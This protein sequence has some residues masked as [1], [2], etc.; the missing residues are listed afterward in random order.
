MGQIT[1]VGWTSDDKVPKFAR[2]TTYGAGASS[3]GASPKYLLVCGTKTAA[4]SA[5][6]DVDIV[7]IVGEDQ[8][9]AFFGA[10]SEAAMMCYAALEVPGV[11]LKAV[12]P[13]EA[14]GATAATMAIQVTGSWSTPGTIP[15]RLA[16]RTYSIAVG[17]TDTKA[18]VAA[19]ITAAFN[20]VVRSPVSA[21]DDSIDTTTLTTK[22][23]GARA[24]DWVLDFDLSLAP[25]GLGIT[26]TGGSALNGNAKP[27]ANG[28]GAD[29]V[30]NVLALM[31]ERYHYQ[32]WA[33]YDGTNI[34]EILAKLDSDAG[35]LVQNLGHAMFGS[36]RAAAT[37]NSLSNT[38]LNHERAS[39][40]WQQNSQ[41]PAS[42]IAANVMAWRSVMESS[43][44]NFN[45]D[46]FPVDVPVQSNAADKPLH[47][48]LK[49]A[50]NNGVTPLM[51]KDGKTVIVRGIVSHCKTGANFDYST[52]DWGDAVV[53]DYVSDQLAVQ[54][55]IFRESNPY[56]GPDP[57]DDEQPAPEGVGTPKLWNAEAVAIMKGNESALLVQDVDTNPPES[58]WDSTAKRILTACPVV[59]RSQNHQGGV[60]VRQTAAA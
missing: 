19:A 44:P 53:P 52:L 41:W 40:V 13:A 56:A 4:G 59:V 43:N 57:A 1:I 50:L 8:A 46:D 30:T 6:P 32:A 15:F 7:D 38:T 28:T 37:A 21:A 22:S 16:G 25:A 11:N 2:Q 47:A 3:V 27:F 20:A 35:P 39:N 45:Y 18:Q 51:N 49:A 9:D 5:T 54:W 26:L 60:D 33:Q 36:A 29:S 34:A 24:N 42:M 55:A 10:G 14:G 17:S 31:L 12:A 23:K 58:Q 48:T